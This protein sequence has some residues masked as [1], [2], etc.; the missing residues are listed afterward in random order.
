M[1]KPIDPGEGYR[2]LIPKVDVNQEGDEW[3]SYADEK[4]LPR[5]FFIGK[6]FNSDLNP[7][8][9]RI[10]QPS[11]P[12]IPVSEKPLR[13]RVYLNGSGEWIEYSRPP[14]WRGS[15][16]VEEFPSDV[17]RDAALQ[18]REYA[19]KWSQEHAS[20]QYRDACTDILGILEDEA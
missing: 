16:A 9:R 19:Q 12:W 17:D 10:E 14:M 2:L 8:R 11:S 5:E 1:T 15:V 4:W 3:W 20:S 13:R 6:M 18:A 7:S